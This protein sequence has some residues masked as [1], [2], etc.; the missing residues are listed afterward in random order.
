MTHPLADRCRCCGVPVEGRRA[1]VRVCIGCDLCDHLH[2]DVLQGIL[3]RSVNDRQ[4]DPWIAI[5]RAMIDDAQ[6]TGRTEYIRNDDGSHDIVINYPPERWRVTLA[7]ALARNELPDLSSVVQAIL[8]RWL[9]AP[10]TPQLVASIRGDMVP[11]LQ[12]ID[13]AIMDVEIDCKRDIADPGNLIIKISART[14]TLGGYIGE[15]SGVEVPPDIMSRPRG[16]A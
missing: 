9:P 8:E 16:S 14:P 11:A 7:R 3:W 2:G 13:A 1:Q 4:L 10:F 12:I 5:A 15:A 6:L